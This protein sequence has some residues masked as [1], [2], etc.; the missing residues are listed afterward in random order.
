MGVLNI[1]IGAFLVI[2]V[3]TILMQP[4]N[5]LNQEAQNVLENQGQT[6]K[7]A[8]NS[9]G[10]VVEVGP[11]SALSGVTTAL[12]YF[13]GLAI[14]AGFVVWIIRYGRGGVYEEPTD[15]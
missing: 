5:I 15:F 2:I 11:A 7:Y 4:V 3:L 14:L 6:I 9:Q 10:E 8:T 1:I 12:M 13:I